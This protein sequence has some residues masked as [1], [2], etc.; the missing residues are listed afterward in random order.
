MDI[1]SYNEA[2]HKARQQQQEAVA[3]LIVVVEAVTDE[4]VAEFTSNWLSLQLA[5]QRQA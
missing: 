5:A 3:G 2:Q 1:F 4:D